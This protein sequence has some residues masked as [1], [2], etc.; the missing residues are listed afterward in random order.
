MGLMGEGLL[1]IWNDIDP[2]LEDDYNL[3]HTQEHL[4]ER[5]G[6]EGFLAGRRYVNPGLAQQRYF[7]L[8]EAQ[9]LAVFNS[10]PYL[11]RLNAPT[12]WTQAMM[13]G[14]ANY[15]RGA[16]QVEYSQSL[17]L[18]GKLAAIRIALNDAA[19]LLASA[20][21]LSGQLRADGRIVGVHLASCSADVTLTPTKERSFRRGTSDDVFDALVLIEAVNI[22]ALDGALARVRAHLHGVLGDNHRADS[23][24]YE[25]AYYL[26]RDQAAA[27]SLR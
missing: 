25:L 23:A 2:A 26:A 3:W 16:C 10:T 27:G 11:A 18:G 5:I 7:T 21:S 22:P 14:F 19:P 9:T 4:P 24:Y 17:A 6:T 1:A 13:P 8:Y 20:E 15:V 12:A